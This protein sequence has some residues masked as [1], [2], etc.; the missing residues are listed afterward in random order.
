MASIVSNV[1][2]D[3]YENGSSLTKVG[4]IYGEVGTTQ[5]TCHALGNLEQGDYVQVY[6][7]KFGWVLGKVDEIKRKT[8]LTLEKAIKMRD[9]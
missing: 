2:S 6:H 7:E 1:S 8:N 5:F 3:D 4:I 9:I